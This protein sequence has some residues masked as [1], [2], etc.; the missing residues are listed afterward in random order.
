M[1]AIGNIT[2]VIGLLLWPFVHPSGQVERN[3]LHAV[4]GLLLGVSISINLLTLRRGCCSNP[5]ENA[6]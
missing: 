3:W 1:R 6:Q 4:C 2:L 5:N